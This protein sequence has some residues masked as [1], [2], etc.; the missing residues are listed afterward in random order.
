MSPFEF[1]F[2]LFGLLLGLSMVEVFQG[3]I[4]TM[5]S[6]TNVRVG[7]LT[8]M[9]GVLVLLHLTTFWDDAW[10]LR[11]K[12]PMNNITLFI[13]LLI[14]GTYYYAASNVFPDRAEEWPSLDEYYDIARR[15]V[16]PGIVAAQL[17]STSA[18]ML[19]NVRMPSMRA[20]FV[21]SLFAAL[22]IAP[23]V[24]R[25]RKASGIV[26]AVV[27]FLFLALAIISSLA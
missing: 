8:P 16:L 10:N 26:L 12:M 21:I 15:K 4:R 9:L 20:L 6:R 27:T 14:S 24:I 18:T 7:W 17:L 3:L 11:E 2:S 19:L 1:V 23:A 5:K 13:G 25:N 22:F